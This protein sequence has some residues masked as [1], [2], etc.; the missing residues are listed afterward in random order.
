M[1]ALFSWFSNILILLVSNS[2]FPPAVISDG[3]LVSTKN[4]FMIKRKEK[5]FVVNICT[6]GVL[7]EALLVNLKD[8][9]QLLKSVKNKSID[10]LQVLMGGGGGRH[11][12]LLASGGG[13]IPLMMGAFECFS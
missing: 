11:I 5:F 9:D 1:L 6:Y 8:K 4:T 7:W 3:I 13:H 12:P 2:L 10:S